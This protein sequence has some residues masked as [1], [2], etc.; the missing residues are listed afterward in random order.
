MLR[1]AAGISRSLITYYGPV[2]RRGRMEALY[3]RFLQAGDLAFDIGAHVGNRVRIFRR[4]GARVIAVEPQ[5]DFVAVLRLLYGRD[6]DVVIEASGVAAGSGEGKL[7]LSTRTPTVSTFA[8]SWIDDVQT[9]RRFQRIRWDT[10]INV[11]LVSLDGLISRHG[12]PQFC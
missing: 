1:R 8:D 11:P 12:E 7:Y 3:R 5:P 2:W 6:P 9:D 4:I 10:V